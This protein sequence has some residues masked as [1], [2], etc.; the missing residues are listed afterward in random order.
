[1]KKMAVSVPRHSG[2]NGD[3]YD[4]SSTM[5]GNWFSS[6]AAFFKFLFLLRVGDASKIK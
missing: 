4:E 1:M 2:V 6:I 5:M 3:D